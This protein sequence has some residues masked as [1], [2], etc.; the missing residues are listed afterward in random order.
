MH[1]VIVDKKGIIMK[2]ETMKKLLFCFLSMFLCSDLHGSACF[3]KTV[4]EGMPK[5][6]ARFFLKNLKGLAAVAGVFTAGYSLY[7]FMNSEPEVPPL[8]P[9]GAVDDTAGATDITEDTTDI[10]AGATSGVDLEGRADLAEQARLQSG[11]FYV[12]APSDDYISR[13]GTIE[14]LGDADELA[15]RQAAERGDLL[16]SSAPRFEL[17]TDVDW[18][19]FAKESGLEL[20]EL[21]S[22]ARG[23]FARKVGPATG[24]VVTGEVTAAVT[25]LQ[26]LARGR[27][28][29]GQVDDLVRAEVEKKRLEALERS[30]PDVVGLM[31][32]DEISVNGGVGIRPELLTFECIGIGQADDLVYRVPVASQTGLFCGVHAVKNALYMLV[33]LDRGDG[34]YLKAMGMPTAPFVDYAFLTIDQKAACM[35]AIVDEGPVPQDLQ[36]ILDGEGQLKE[37]HAKKLEE[38][39]DKNPL[40]AHL[41]QGIGTRDK[42][43][44]VPSTVLDT[45]ISRN[46]VAFLEDQGWKKEIKRSVL[47]LDDI[48]E[49][50]PKN[51]ER[52]TEEKVDFLL[53]LAKSP[54]GQ[55]AFV[56]NP[57]GSAHWISFVVKKVEGFQ[58]WYYMNSKDSVDVDSIHRFIDR[59]TSKAQIEYFETWKMLSEFRH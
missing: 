50:L 22:L 4:L 55:W 35:E 28:A 21:Q 44:N 53:D 9:G 32:V 52:L 43:Q 36:R 31:P 2:K 8:T 34:G 3:Q 49:F 1:N 41:I 38:Y 5:S 25:K 54:N 37:E 46:G 27:A 18:I 57:Q 13:S 40:M 10:A 48:D 59:M 11:L 39:E 20:T 42:L 14:D 6:T 45:M 19:E 26:A 23:R 24:V 58:T 12:P 33:E 7:K 56:M 51:G 16:K 29:R 47:V 15:A 30:A 17:M